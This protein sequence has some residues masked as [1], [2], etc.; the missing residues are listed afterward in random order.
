MKEIWNKRYSDENYVYGVEPNNFFREQLLKLTPGKILLPAEGEGRNAV[1][2]AK[3]GWQVEAFDISEI[4]GEKAMN[5]AKDN[6]VIINYSIGELSSLAY[7]QGSFD[8]V[9][10]IFAHVTAKLR[11]ENHKKMITLLKKGG[12]VIIEGFSTKHIGFQKQNPGV[13]GPKDLDFLYTKEEIAAD[14]SGFEVLLL[15]EKVIE[16]NEGLYHIGT[17]SVIRFVGRKT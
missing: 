1:F 13:G 14:F 17:G 9:G 11:S 16:L 4:A 12:V 3:N 2:A 10:L 15:E 6:N 5:L 7:L 8:A